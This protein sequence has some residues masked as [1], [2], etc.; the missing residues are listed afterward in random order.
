MW[1]RFILHSYLSHMTNN[2]QF[3]F[4]GTSSRNFCGCKGFIKF[5]ALDNN[6]YFLYGYKHLYVFFYNGDD[7]NA[8]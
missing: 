2:G 4:L 3:H 5:C 7:R 1:L 6:G 8:F